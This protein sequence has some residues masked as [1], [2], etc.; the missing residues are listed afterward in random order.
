MRSSFS[1]AIQLVLVL[2]LWL[3]L[4]RAAGQSAVSLGADPAADPS[5][6]KLTYRRVFKG[7]T[8]EYLSIR[9][10]KNG[11]GEYEGRK[12]SDP[13]QPR[14]LKLSPD[15]TRQLFELADRL[16]DFHTVDLESH[17]KVADLG[18]KTFIYEV[19]GQKHSAEFNYT[20]NRDA[21]DLSDLFE[22]IAMVEQ[23]IA[24]LE[25]AIK[26]DHLGL[27]QELR[28]IQIELDNQALADPELLVP[29]LEEIARNPRFLH[30]AQARAQNILQR[31]QNNN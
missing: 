9:V 6:P 19:G 3:G 1:C 5:V 18:Q 31:I 27:P 17:R 29:T 24:G 12:L 8:P 16:S 23:H 10:D 11:A 30:L 25:F 28:E 21:R 7:S 15:I 13:T 20:I 26:Y 14:P 22:K 4:S 2:G